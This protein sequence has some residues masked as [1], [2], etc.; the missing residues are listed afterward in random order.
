M[1]VVGCGG[2]CGCGRWFA[3]GQTA[4]SDLGWRNER[5]GEGEERLTSRSVAWMVKW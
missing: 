3:C 2:C 4:D 5:H 1:R